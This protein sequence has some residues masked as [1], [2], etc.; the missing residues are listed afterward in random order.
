MILKTPY[1]APVLKTYDV[2]KIQ[3][4][5]AEVVLAGEYANAPKL[6]E[7]YEIYKSPNPMWT[8]NF[9]DDVIA[10][11]KNT[12]WKTTADPFPFPIKVRTASGKELY[13]VDFRPHMRV[14]N[15]YRM[16]GDMLNEGEVAVFEDA[17]SWMRCWD[18]REYGDIRR[19]H[20]Y[21]TGTFANWVASAI[22][23]ITGVSGGEDYDIIR[24][25]AAYWFQAQFSEVPYEV[26]VEE[27]LR[28]R[29]V[30]TNCW[31][32]P[33]SVVDLQTKDFE[34]IGS[35][36]DYLEAIKKLLP[37]NRRLKMLNR[38]W[39]TQQLANNWRG[40]NG[41]LWCNVALEYPPFFIA[42]YYN[43]LTNPWAKDCSFSRIA[44]NLR[45]TQKRA[46][47]LASY[48]RSVNVWKQP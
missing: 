13:A 24:F 34:Y 28:M 47:F 42:M 27:R 11:C 30:M 25:L 4:Q 19:V 38:A 31:P 9:A 2:K 36:E 17:I 8:Y 44:Q 40:I 10:L 23:S 20:D 29:R 35:L 45:D 32:R 21:V 33:D 41:G 6:K 18:H 14:A 26:T 15:H 16:Y 7:S 3:L 5:I 39:F 43:A 46:D 48:R 22:S 12:D 37:N 1:D